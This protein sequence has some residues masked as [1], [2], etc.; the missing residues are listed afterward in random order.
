VGLNLFFG[1]VVGLEFR[2]GLAGI[3][4]V[5]RDSAMGLGFSG[6]GGYVFRFWDDDRKR[7]KLEMNMLAGFFLA[8]DSGNDLA[9]NAGGMLIGIGYEMPL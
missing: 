7:I 6:G 3:S 1:S 9:T 4:Q 5:G 2:L 8:D